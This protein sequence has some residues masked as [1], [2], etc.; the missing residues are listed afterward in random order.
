MKDS[1]TSHSL[2]S[3]PFDIQRNFITAIGGGVFNWE[4]SA[5]SFYIGNSIAYTTNLGG[6]QIMIESRM[7]LDGSVF[8]VVKMERWVLGKDGAYHFEPMPSSRDHRFIELTRFENKEAALE[9]VIDHE[10][11]NAGKN[12]TLFV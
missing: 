7:Q 12:P 10:R 5:D 8:W 11:S 3:A 2:F 1:N 4:I 9:A 6:R